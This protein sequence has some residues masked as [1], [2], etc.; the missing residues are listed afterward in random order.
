MVNY[1][2]QQMKG[3]TFLIYQLNG[4]HLVVNATTKENDPDFR[5]IVLANVISG[6]RNVRLELIDKPVMLHPGILDL[7]AYQDVIFEDYTA[8][9]FFC[10]KGDWVKNLPKKV[11]RIFRV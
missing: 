3:K 5:E 2:Y 7:S 6:L 8:P 11:V 4:D 1:S 9:I 10:I